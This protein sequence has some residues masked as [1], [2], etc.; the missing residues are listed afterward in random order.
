MSAG[1]AASLVGSAGVAADVA[2]LAR[3]DDEGKAARDYLT[4]SQDSWLGY[5]LHRYIPDS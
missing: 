3:L 5:A 2:Q 4:G 1:L